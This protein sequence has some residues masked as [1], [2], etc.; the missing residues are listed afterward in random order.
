MRTPASTAGATPC[1]TRD[2]PTC[3]ASGLT[4]APASLL[5]GPR[6][7]D[8]QVAFFEYEGARVSCYEPVAAPYGVDVSTSSPEGTGFPVRLCRNARRS[9]FSSAVRCSGTISG[10]RVPEAAGPPPAS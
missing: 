9:D 2:G 5:Q 6:F 10:D 8:D 3:I 4:Y 7:G 1:A